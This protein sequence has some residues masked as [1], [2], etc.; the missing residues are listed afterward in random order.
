MECQS[1]M[2]EPKPPTGSDI[3]DNSSLD[4][5]KLAM[6]AT[7]NTPK[8]SQILK[9]RKLLRMLLEEVRQGDDKKLRLK[10]RNA[11]MTY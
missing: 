3:S 4:F 9:V 11:W 6:M 10:L 1:Q 2:P 5:K 7:K 8:K